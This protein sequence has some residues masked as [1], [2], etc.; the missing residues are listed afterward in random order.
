MTTRT[1]HLGGA[2][3]KQLTEIGDTVFGTPCADEIVVTDP[4]IVEVRAGGGAD[5]IVA[6]ANVD[7]LPGGEGIYL[8]VAS[9][10][11]SEVYGGDGDDEIYGDVGPPEAE[12]VVASKR[13]RRPRA[14]LSSSPY[15]CQT[16]S[17]GDDI[18]YM[19]TGTTTY[20]GG[21]GDDIIFGQ[22]GGDNIFGNEGSDRLYGG[23]GD[24]PTIDG[25]E[26]SDLLS[27]GPGTDELFGREGND[28][29]RGDGNPDELFGGPGTDTLSFSSG[30]SPGF[31][32]PATVSCDGP[33]ACPGFPSTADGRGL[34]IDLTQTDVEFAARNGAA[35][36]GGGNDRFDGTF[37]DVIGTAHADYIIGDDGNNTLSGGGGADVILGAGGSDVINGN[38]DGDYLDGGSGTDELTGG[39]GSANTNY[40]VNGESNAQC[41]ATTAGVI[42]RDPSKIAVGMTT[43]VLTRTYH[44]IY[45]TGT[46]GADEVEASVSPGYNVVFTT[47]SGGSEFDPNQEGCVYSDPHQVTCNPSSLD[48]VLMD[49]FGGNDTLNGN[50][51]FSGTASLMLFGGNGADELSGAEKTEDVLVDGPDSSGDVLR[52]Y[53]HDD[54]LIGA[55]GSDNLIAGDDND[56]MLTSEIC[57]GGGY[58]GQAGADNIAFAPVPLPR[59][60]VTNGVWA[61]LN[62]DPS[63]GI[64]GRVGVAASIEDSC[65]GG[66]VSDLIG[67]ENLEGTGGVDLLVGDANQNNL[68]GRAG[69]DN[70]FG[71]GGDDTIQVNSGDH[72]EILEGGAGAGDILFQD[73][74]ILGDNAIDRDQATAEIYNQSEPRWDGY[75]KPV[76][77]EMIDEASSPLAFFRLGE[78]TGS[79][80]YEGPE[81]LAGGNNGTYLSGPTLGAD[82]A[83][84]DSDNKAIRLDGTN[85]SVNLTDSWDP[86]SYSS[87]GYSIEFWIKPRANQNGLTRYVFSRFNGSN[88]VYVFRNSAG[89]L[90]LGS[91]RGGNIFHVT[92]TASPSTGAWHHVVGIL[93]GNMSTLYVDNVATSTNFGQ[94]VF[95]NAAVSTPNRLGNYPAAGF[96]EADLDT[97]SIYG[98]ALPAGEIAQ[99]YSLSFPG[100]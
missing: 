48:V 15:P 67:V 85:D 2:C 17:P 26:G 28:L 79:V 20:S 70:L 80:A 19:D 42:G 63:R 76:D 6:A 27:G 38:A 69:V 32:S 81:P 21:L 22:R 36:S 73:F 9:P 96:L 95:P 37:E 57:D 90:V 34:Y 49:G 12:A 3:S 60:S 59:R 74:V 10:E 31:T 53:G 13:L 100:S 7:F 77:N 35:L 89:K 55:G 58:F 64:A 46:A 62:F 45:L 71:L 66:Q 51:D 30:A 14:R 72:D 50:Y 33:G 43:R 61:N 24:D 98:R 54:A 40:C 41:G 65:P 88:G 5:T 99:H 93:N 11:V 23:I 84:A 52:G 94:S 68:L 16:P 18:C 78:R 75:F 1:R 47:P 91:R 39:S 87:S 92:S 8:I 86:A 83:I 25:G 97:L 44:M 56:V 29:L 82:S 4:G